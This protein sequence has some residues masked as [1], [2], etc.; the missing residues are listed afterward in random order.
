MIRTDQYVFCKARTY[1]RRATSHSQHIHPRT[2]PC[3]GHAARYLDDAPLNSLSKRA[4]SVNGDINVG[5]DKS[6]L[7]V[8]HAECR[9]AAVA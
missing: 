7:A 3:K 2:R 6:Y 8:A 9:R 1:R 4:G 5:L